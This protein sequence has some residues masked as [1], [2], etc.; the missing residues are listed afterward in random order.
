MFNVFSIKYVFDVVYFHVLSQNMYLA[1]EALVGYNQIF[2]QVKYHA[3][4]NIN[5]FR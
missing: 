4:R 2:F 3:T 5:L 1:D